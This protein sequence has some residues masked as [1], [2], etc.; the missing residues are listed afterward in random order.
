MNKQAFLQNLGE[1]PGHAYLLRGRADAPKSD[2]AQ[3][4]AALF[5]GTERER[6]ALHPDYIL[7]YPQKKSIGVDEIRRLKGTLAKKP[8]SAKR[9]VC[10]VG[11][12]DALTIQA[13]NAMLKMLEEPGEAVFILLCEGTLLPTVESRCLVVPVPSPNRGEWEGALLAAGFSPEESRVYASVGKHCG[14]SPLELANSEAL[15]HLRHAVIEGMRRLFSKHPERTRFLEFF[16]KERQYSG[17]LLAVALSFFRDMLAYLLQ[18]E[19]AGLVNLDM[20]KAVVGGSRYF[21]YGQLQGM[22]NC[23][24]L[25]ERQLQANV[26]YALA[27]ENML[28]S[29]M[30]VPRR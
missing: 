24:L 19:E 7:I 12:G 9:R 20:K 25:C 18:G 27:V 10:V 3:D 28:I 26:N 22:I 16:K 21:T 13:Q 23:V 15:R 6:L 11:E 29:M 4:M 8:F 30:E 5:L 1:F 17:F 2:W 14:I